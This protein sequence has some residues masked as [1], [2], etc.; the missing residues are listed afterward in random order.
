ML[1]ELS[2]ILFATLT[3]HSSRE[4]Y[5]ARAAVG[6]KNLALLLSH[7]LASSFDKMDLTL[8][9]IKDEAERQLA[10]GGVAR[11]S[12]NAF[13]AKQAARHAEVQLARMTGGNG[14][15]EFG[16]GLPET[17]AHPVIAEREYFITLKNDPNAALVVSKPLQGKISGEWAIVFARRVNRA[18]GAFA[19]V[20]YMSV[21][22]A[23]FQALF[24]TLN[25]GP[26]GVVNL[27]DLNLAT[28]VRYPDT[29]PRT[30]TGNTTVSK[31]WRQELKIN[32]QSGTYFAVGLDGLGRLLS[33]HRIA[34]YPFY[35]IVAHSPADFLDGWSRE[36]RN[37]L[38]LMLAAAVAILAFAWLTLGVWRRNETNARRMSEMS[39]RL[40]EVQE[41]ERR[42]LAAE[43][44]DVTSPNLAALQI[45][46]KIIQARLPASVNRDLQP[47][48][49]QARDMLGEITLNLRDVCANL[50]PTMLDYSGL[51]PAL[52]DYA[53][54]FSSG[55][56]IRVR[57]TGNR[58][59]QRLAPDIESL[60]FRIAQ[61]AVTNAAKHAHTASIEIELERTPAHTRLCIQDCGIGFDPAQIGQHG[62]PGLGLL[63]MRERAEFVGGRFSL[64]SSPGQGTRITVEI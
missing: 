57:V 8:L 44:H 61:E 20:A 58:S 25:L 62:R 29:T 54:H 30:A 46:L 5:D 21:T 40:I 27:R 12:L 60:L 31:E 39:H 23:H 64:S 35:I 59:A 19:G 10:A 41:G 11:A 22:L 18:D 14:V 38:A 52:H 51:L 37:T 26:N 6:G 7:D 3:L 17:G 33:Y 34:G 56:S 16:T 43:L 42:K 50:R 1:L 9:A 32:P 28:V 24:A 47:Q 53:R 49:A 15:V 55:T 36:V 13:I 48:F 4:Q 2:L 45:G 63:T